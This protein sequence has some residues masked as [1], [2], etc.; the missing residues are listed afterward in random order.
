MVLNVGGLQLASVLLLYVAL[1][2]F[3]QAIKDHTTRNRKSG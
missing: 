1:D 3:C 2:I